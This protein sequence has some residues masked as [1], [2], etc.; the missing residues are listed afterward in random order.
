VGTTA[1]EVNEGHNIL[2]PL[3][4][5]HPGMMSLTGQ[6]I[7]CILS[8]FL[9]EGSGKEETMPSLDD[10]EGLGRPALDILEWL[11]Q[12]AEQKVKDENKSHCV[13]G[14]KFWTIS[15]L[16]TCIVIRWLD[17]AS[18]HNIATEFSIF[19]GNVQRGLLKVA[20]L[21]EEWGAIATIRKDLSTLEK[22]TNLRF[23]RDDIVVDSL[24]LRM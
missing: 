5:E 6:D 12:E 4:A 20:N 17:G 8:A 22:L 11:T 18:L 3:L 16:W 19:E 21:L 23:L 9:H 13:S 24:Y 2:M 14:L 7:A 15:P 10:I 1:T